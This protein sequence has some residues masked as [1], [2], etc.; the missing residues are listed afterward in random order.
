MNPLTWYESSL[1]NDTRLSSNSFQIH[2]S[3]LK[4]FATICWDSPNKHFLNRLSHTRFRMYASPIVCVRIEIGEMC[5]Y[6]RS[7]SPYCVLLNDVVAFCVQ[8]GVME[9]HII[10]E[11][12]RERCERWSFHHHHPNTVVVQ[13]SCLVRRVSQ[14]SEPVTGLSFNTVDGAGYMCVLCGCV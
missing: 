7:A 4:V 9:V 1:R 3:T 5:S 2:S 11:E 13:R 14:P 12:E 8:G 6:T 10:G